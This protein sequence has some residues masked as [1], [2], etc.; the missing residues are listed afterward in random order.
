MTDTS[1]KPDIRVPEQKT[2]AL[3]FCDTTP[4]AFRQWIGLLP[5]ANIGEASRQLYHAIIELNQ[6]FLQPQQ[7][8]QL[9]E[10]IREKIHYVCEELSRHFLTIAVSL[11]EKQRK[12][13][14]LAQAL[15]MHLAAGY[16]LCVTDL[17][18]T[19]SPEKHRKALST[20]IQR[21]IA[22]LSGTILRAYQLYCPA[23]PN[24]WRECHQLYRF[25]LAHRLTT[26][27][28]DD[29]VMSQHSSSS[30]GDAYK[31]ALLLGCARPNQLRQSKLG[32]LFTLLEPWAELT[33]CKPGA[34]GDSLFLVNLNAD[35]S[36][37]YRSLQDT[38]ADGDFFSFDSRRLSAQINLAIHSADGKA[39]GELLLPPNT[40][41]ALLSHLAQALGT[42]AKRNFNRLASYSSLELCVGLSA[43]HYFIAGRKTFSDFISKPAAEGDENN[44]FI[45]NSQRKNDAWAGAYDADNKHDGMLADNTPVNFSSASTRTTPTPKNA[46]RACRAQLV[47]TSPG[48]Y[49]IAWDSQI[50]SNLQ[51]GE[52]LGVREQ[53]SQSWSVAVVRWIRQIKN[54]GTQIGIELQA[55]RATPCAVRLIQKLG[56]SS[57]YLRGLMLPEIS[58]INQPATL[59]VPRLPFQSGS[60][61]TLLIND[62]EKQGQLLEKLTATGSINQFEI[63]LEREPDAKASASRSAPGAN[64]DDFD[65]LWP[66]L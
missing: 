32:Q 13:A 28:I 52:I 56:N 54:Q 37:I 42:P 16:K 34:A 25:A 26:I 2:A 1:L 55:P 30:V 66:S 33:D 49:C 21:G 18:D 20:A 12:I 15:Q 63:K 61:I 35:K 60:R 36:P 62:Q 44:T 38:N 45:R 46:P 31:R 39:P 43:A 8:L 22:E 24:S 65:S 10:L 27:R 50:P 57:E 3:S 58:V 9:L 47:N 29:L 64:E 7:R 59:I 48:G 11:P 53:S 23:P 40:S 51:T 6:L 19:G 14:N 17:L 5:M 4:K 41:S